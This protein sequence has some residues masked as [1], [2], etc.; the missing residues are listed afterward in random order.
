VQET[1]RMAAPLQLAGR[2]Q[3]I[4]FRSGKRTQTFMSK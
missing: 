2:D 1:N 3:N 4:G